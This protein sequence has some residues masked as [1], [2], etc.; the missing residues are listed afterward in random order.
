M[1]LTALS[2]LFV[3]WNEFTTRLWSTLF[4]VDGVVIIFFL[5]KEIFNKRCGFLAGLV[6]ATSLQYLI[7]SRLALL[8]VTLS[9]FI[10]LSF[11]FFCLDNNFLYIFFG[12]H[13]SHKDFA[14]EFHILIKVSDTTLFFHVFL[15]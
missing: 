5:G 4:G 10:S 3:G 2:F 12:L 13:L 11:L 7:Q 14:M 9:F 8:D 1:W 15:Q 6:P